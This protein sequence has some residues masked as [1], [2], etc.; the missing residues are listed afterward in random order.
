MLIY[1]Q[2]LNTPEEQSKFEQIYDAYRGLMFHVAYRILGNTHDAEDAVQQAFLVILDNLGKIS[3]I[4][5]PK[6][7]SFV[8]TIVERKSIDLYRSKRRNA[9]LPLEEEAVN[10]PSP[11]EVDAVAERTVFAK[12]MA[13]LPTRYRELL[14]LKYDNGYSEREI[15]AMC[16]M[17][18][19]NVSK[20]IQ[21]AKKKLKAILSE[22]G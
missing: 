22:Q 16:S 5:C 7:R 18:E 20:T 1:T 17:T 13:T 10:V 8:V 4:R 14:F 11:S 6:S 15:A 12:A 2:M 3:E 19:A 9:V 21:R